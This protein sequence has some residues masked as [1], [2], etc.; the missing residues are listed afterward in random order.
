MLV[1]VSE[2]CEKKLLA[3]KQEEK[4]GK[5]FNFIEDWYIHLWEVV[6]NSDRLFLLLLYWH[7]Y[8][9]FNLQIKHC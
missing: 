5:T 9:A 8:S 3:V 7:L 2:Q 6:D 1:T 4:S